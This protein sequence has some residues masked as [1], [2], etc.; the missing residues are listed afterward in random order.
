LIVRN[1]EVVTDPNKR[2]RH[3]KSIHGHKA[4]AKVDPAA[5]KKITALI[6][7]N[8]YRTLMTRGMKG[9]YVFSTDQETADYFRSLLN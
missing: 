7:K 9:C 6:I 2:D 4:L 5:A 1:G 3:D 8:T